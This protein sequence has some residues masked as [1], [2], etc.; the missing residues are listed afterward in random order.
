MK[1]PSFWARG[2]SGNFSCWR[3]SFKSVEEAQSLAIAAAQQLA[4]RFRTGDFLP[5]HSGYYPDRPFREPVLREIKNAA[6]ETSA[7][8]SRNSYGCQVLNTARV[9]FV[10]VDFPEP[11]PAGLFQR[12]FGKSSVDAAAV[13]VDSVIEKAK[14]WAQANPGWGWRIYRTRAGMRLLATHDLMEPNSPATDAV[15]DALGSDPLYRRLCRAQKYFRARL[16]PKPWRCGIRHKPPRWPWSDAKVEK[17]F[18]KWDAQYQSFSAGWATCEYISSVGVSDVHPEIAAV[19]R[20][21]DE[22]T[23]AVSKLKLA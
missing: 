4:D 3:W 15:F 13:T 22:N 21:H 1:F 6:D 9:M 16:T 5:K 7:I 12:I 17:M 10:D 11:K 20:I 8:L 14:Q 2:E 18:Q 19:L 23:R